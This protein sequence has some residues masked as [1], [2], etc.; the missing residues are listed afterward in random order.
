[1]FLI[2]F[3]SFDLYKF[4]H[5]LFLLNLELVVKEVK[6]LANKDL[7]RQALKSCFSSKQLGNEEFLSE[8]VGNACSNALNKINFINTSSLN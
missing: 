7:V 8:L 5:F 3:K 6:D 4:I 2:F 1:L